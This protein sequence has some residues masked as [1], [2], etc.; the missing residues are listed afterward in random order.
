MPAILTGS[1]YALTL[2]ASAYALIA[3]VCR[4]RTYR[5]GTHAGFASARQPVTPSAKIAPT[6][7][8]CI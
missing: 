7:V 2:F 4:P 6:D 8:I 1:G 3:L 5:L